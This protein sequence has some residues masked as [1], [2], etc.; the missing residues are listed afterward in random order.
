MRNSCWK[1]NA[2]NHK[3]YDN[4]NLLHPEGAWRAKQAASGY[5]WEI[6]LIIPSIHP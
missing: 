1:Q 6:D 4:H 5:P 3:I 2:E